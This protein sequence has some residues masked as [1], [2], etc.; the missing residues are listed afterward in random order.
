MGM[1]G[2]LTF[3]TPP[4]LGGVENQ[5]PNARTF[6]ELRSN[7]FGR[8]VSYLALVVVGGTVLAAQIYQMNCLEPGL[9]IASNVSWNAGLQ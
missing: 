8:S 2:T 9:S 4:V 5:S 1:H 6:V 3:Y 7:Q